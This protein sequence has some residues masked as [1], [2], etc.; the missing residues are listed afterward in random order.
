[1]HQN[2]L[3]RLLKGEVIV[4]NVAFPHKNKGVNGIISSDEI[5][6]SHFTDYHAEHL[7]YNCHRYGYS[8]NYLSRVVLAILLL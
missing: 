8:Y 2:L 5:F 3:G 4:P 6:H 7:S 1:M